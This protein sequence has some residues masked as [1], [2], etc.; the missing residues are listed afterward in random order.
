MTTPVLAPIP[1]RRPQPSAAPLPAAE[2]KI[3]PRHLASAA[4]IYVRQ[5][6]PSQVQRHPESARRQ[7]GLVTRAQA[8]GWPVDQ[9]TVID[10]DQGKSAAGSAAAHERDGFA[11]LV[12]AVGLGEVGII[13]AL[14]VSRLARNSAEW[15]RL[16]EL[17]ALAGVLI[18][19]DATVYD[20]RLFNDRLLLG[21]RGTVSEIELHCIQERLRGARRSKAERGELR[22]RLPAGYVYGS[23]GRVEFDPDEAVQAAVRVIF[24]QF[25]RRGSAS[26]VL[27]FCTEHALLLPRQRWLA[28]TPAG[29]R[30]LRATY[31]A[32]LGILTNPFYAGAYVYG[33][34]RT[35]PATLA[36][37]PVRRRYNLDGVE[38]LLKDH[39]PAYLSWEQYER[40][41]AQLRD[42]ASRY[43]SHG[44]PRRGSALLQGLVVCGR[45]GCRMQV[46]YDSARAVY[47]CNSRH[48]LYGEPICQS[49]ASPHVD[50]AVSAAFLA[51]IQPAEIEAAL[52]V[53]AAA[54]HD[55][56][57]VEQQWQYRLERARYEV[58][59]AQRQYDLVEPENRLVARELERRWNEQLRALTEL[60]AAHQRELGRGLTAASAAERAAL[61]RLV[62]DLPGLWASLATLPEERK[63]LLRCLVQHVILTRDARPHRTGGITHVRIEWRGGA[64]TDLRVQ[65]PSVGDHTRTAAAVLERVR[66][67]VGNQETDEQIAAILNAEGATTSKGLPWTAARVQTRRAYFGITRGQADAASRQRAHEQGLVSTA[68]VGARL[69]VSPRTVWDWSVHGLLP[70]TQ[71]A[72]GALRWVAL[73]PDEVSRLDGTLAANGAG[74]WGM[75]EA[76][77]VLRLDRAGLEACLRTGEL[78][79]YR[80]QK[81]GRWCWRISP[82]DAA[83]E[84]PAV[85]GTP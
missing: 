16:L 23:D 77:R 5:S 64:W 69:G 21:L 62:E 6:H 78:I 54:E 14:E 76:Q 15:Y 75:R 53:A 41:G 72:D 71:A 28:Q 20:P 34:R 3:Q 60:E 39:H 4:I 63:R 2:A 80:V 8:L 46:Y 59:R 26:A 42:N 73:T 9:I 52:A 83:A 57:L 35:T 68:A 31:Q 40:N 70:T 19:D 12:S 50:E 37:A 65:R 17:A 43:A 67:L 24:E 79:A 45:C 66:T 30:W 10:A 11:Q 74:R 56:A 48:Q 18:A 33:Y 1:T 58:E 36:A 22:L 85:S 55:R 44:A 51:V 32:I 49:L 27:H 29:I 25:R 7:Y 82:A 81:Q 13:L 84:R 61:A 47:I 38:V